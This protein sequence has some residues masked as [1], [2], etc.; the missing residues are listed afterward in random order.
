[1][2]LGSFVASS[3]HRLSRPMA[4]LVSAGVVAGF[5]VAVVQSIAGCAGNSFPLTGATFFQVRQVTQGAIAMTTGSTAS[6]PVVFSPA[7]TMPQLAIQNLTGPS[8]FVEGVLLFADN[9]NATPSSAFPIKQQIAGTGPQTGPTSA[10]QMLSNLVFAVPDDLG[11]SN[12]FRTEPLGAGNTLP[13]NRAASYF[14]VV[15]WKNAFGQDNFRPGVF[16]PVCFCY[17]TLPTL[18]V[19]GA[20]IIPSSNRAHVS[21]SVTFSVGSGAGGGAGGG[22]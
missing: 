22:G 15:L 9:L 12:G 3:L 2:T 17:T 20:E 4:P 13:P 18:K 5:L 7:I 6:P 14:A 11:F 1:M 8:I 10:D 19:A 16:D 21:Y